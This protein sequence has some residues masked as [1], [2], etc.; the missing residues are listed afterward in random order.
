MEFTCNLEHI[1][2][3]PVLSIH[4]RTAIAGLP[5]LMGR[6]FGAV[7]QYLS[8]LGE[9]PAGPPYVAYYNMDMSDLQV[10]LGFPVERALTGRGE[11]QA[12]NF[13][14]GWQA[15]LVYTGPYPKIGPAYE[16]L[17]EF[18]K[19]NGYEPSGVAIE[20]YLNSPMDTPAEALQT[21]IIFPL[22]S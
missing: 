6:S 9:S 16:A 14:A 21:L 7:A 18:V 10:E 13:A 12:G 8:D 1:E 22:K 17:T 4:A 19:A 2:A 20:F 3:Q 5:E 11:I 15:S